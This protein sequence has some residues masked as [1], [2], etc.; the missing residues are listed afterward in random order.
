MIEVLY[1]V[2]ILYFCELLGLF[3][4]VFVLIEIKSEVYKL[5]YFKCFNKWFLIKIMF[6]RIV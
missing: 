3:E 1:Y 4:D 6:V 2:Y 5:K